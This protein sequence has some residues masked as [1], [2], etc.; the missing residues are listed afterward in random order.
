MNAP[1]DV[2]RPVPDV[3]PGVLLARRLLPPELRA[4]VDRLDGELRQVCGYQLG[5]YDE[6][7][8][9]TGQVIGK[10]LR[11]AFTLLCSAAAGGRPEDAVPAAA[12]IELLHNASLIHDD[13]MDGDTERR[14]R[15]TVWARYGTS[16][17]ILAGDALIALGFEA[18]ADRHDART[19]HSVAVLARSLRL[20]AGGQD[21]DLRFESESTVTVHECLAMMAGKTGVLLGCACRLG[22]ARSPAPPDW[23]VRL[24]GFGVHLGVAFQLVDDV[25]GIW[26]DPAVTGKP[27]GADLRARK[28][29]A[30]VAAALAAG[31]TGPARIAD[32]Y[33]GR[34]PLTDQDVTLLTELIEEAGG[35]AWTLAEADRQVSAAWDLIDDL[36]LDGSARAGLGALTASLMNRDH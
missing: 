8:R 10:L 16:L 7:G 14:H 15:P 22:A 27:V 30:P 17:A 24:E 18:L 32:L 2:V 34:E 33:S 6:D 13:I 12:A 23:A 3:N 11:P 21:L 31:G 35:R 4:W 26:G 36:D 28:K 25:L 29:S 19:A 20:L 9:P 1:I 5:L